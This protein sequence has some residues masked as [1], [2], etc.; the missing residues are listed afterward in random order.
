MLR[1]GTLAFA[2]TAFVGTVSARPRRFNTH[3]TSE[4]HDLDTNAQGQVNFQLR[5]GKLHFKLI[6]ANMTNVTA[7]HIHL[8]DDVLG[9]VAVW[10][11]DFD[12]ESGEL[13]EGR[14]NGVLAEGII[15]DAQV[16]H[17]AEEDVDTVDELVAE[18][19]ADEAW[20]NVHTAELP[21]GEIGGRITA[22][23]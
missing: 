12:T 22:R 1:V 4:A 20:V 19:D 14:V 17:A 7:A 5:N 15:T 13:V 8:D 9:R 6:V 11:H 2:G 16:G 21:G 3:M 10:L 23:N 18:I